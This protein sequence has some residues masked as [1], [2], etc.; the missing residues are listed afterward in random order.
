MCFYCLGAVRIIPTI[1]LLLGVRQP[2]LDVEWS[3]LNQQ[4]CQLLGCSVDQ[5]C[6]QDSADDVGGE[7]WVAL[8]A[9]S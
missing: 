4:N 3:E 8:V 2:A 5:S 9:T 6:Y 1:L 7:L